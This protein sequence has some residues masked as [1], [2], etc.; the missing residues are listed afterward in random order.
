[1][2]YSLYPISIPFRAD[3]L[4]SSASIFYL[5]MYLLSKRDEFVTRDIFTRQI[6]YSRLPFAKRKY[7][8]AISKKIL[9]KQ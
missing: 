7:P 8:R 2:E 6:E 9:Q 4:S 5:F 3:S 1:M